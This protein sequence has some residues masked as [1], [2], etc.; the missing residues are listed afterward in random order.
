MQIPHEMFIAPPYAEPRF[1]IGTTTEAVDVAPIKN[2]ECWQQAFPKGEVDWLTGWR[3]L[4]VA[5]QDLFG[6]GTDYR[7]ERIAIEAEAYFSNGECASKGTAIQVQIYES[8]IWVSKALDLL[9]IVCGDEEVIAGCLGYVV[10][11]SDRNARPTLTLMVS[12][13]GGGREA[14]MMIRSELGALGLS[15]GVMPRTVREGSVGVVKIPFMPELYLLAGHSSYS[16]NWKLWRDLAKNDPSA[17]WATAALLWC[18]SV[19]GAVEKLRQKLPLMVDEVY[20]DFMRLVPLGEELTPSELLAGDPE[21]SELI[22][23]PPYSFLFSPV[24]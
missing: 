18:D 13:P 10:R 11:K 3:S 8:E 7:S 9:A 14:A 23:Q 6:T 19:I 22:D 5:A 2:L 16:V 20:F 1:V 4:W 17:G 24:E 12:G 15:A 21:F